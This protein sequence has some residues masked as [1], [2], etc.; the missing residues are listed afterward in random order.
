M[1]PTQFATANWTASPPNTLSRWPDSARADAPLRQEMAGRGKASVPKAARDSGLI[2]K[3]AEVAG[4]IIAAEQRLA[5][6][7]AS[8]ESLDSTIRLFDPS[9]GP[10]RIKPKLERTAIKVSRSGELTRTVLSVLRQSEKPLT[11]REVA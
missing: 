11:V 9:A 8:L 5:E 4:E 6:M 7:R 2:A 10:R 1:A 3:R